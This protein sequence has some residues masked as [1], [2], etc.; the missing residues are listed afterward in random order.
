MVAMVFA[1]F[2]IHYISYVR[3]RTNVPITHDHGIENI[4]T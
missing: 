3:L 4:S 2:C 1:N